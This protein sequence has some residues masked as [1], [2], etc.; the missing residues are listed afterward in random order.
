MTL[1]RDLGDLQLA[2][3]SGAHSPRLPRAARQAGASYPPAGPSGGVERPRRVVRFAGLMHRRVPR[4]LLAQPCGRWIGFALAGELHQVHTEVAVRQVAIPGGSA[5]EP[6]VGVLKAHFSRGG[7]RLDHAI[8]SWCPAARGGASPSCSIRG[9]DDGRPLAGERSMWVPYWPCRR[10][11][12]SLPRR[13]DDRRAAESCHPDRLRS[14][15]GHGVAGG[16]GRRRPRPRRSSP[17]R[18]RRGAPPPGARRPGGPRVPGAVACR[19]RPENS[20]QRQLQV[21]GTQDSNQEDPQMGAG[22]QDT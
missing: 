8:N 20:G 22:M 10:A 1:A 15:R 3:R 18:S 19:S 13:R 11:P 2:Q 16:S 5:H 6:A 7:F 9:R 4:S 21:A 12:W 17:A 14:A